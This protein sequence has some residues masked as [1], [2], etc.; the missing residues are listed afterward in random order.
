MIDGVATQLQKIMDEYAEKV[1]ETT[2]ECM[3]EVADSTVA[4]LKRT[5]PT[6]KGHT[7]Y[8]RSW[9]VTKKGHQYIVHNK[10]HYRLTHLLEHGHVIKNQ[11][12]TYG[13]T[14]PQKHIKP[15]EEHAQ[16]KLIKELGQKL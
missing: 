4:E 16:A 12:G 7:K 13:R 9:T 5:S 2:D 1:D 15:A 14:T 6:S 11:Y 8:A 3:K 10:R